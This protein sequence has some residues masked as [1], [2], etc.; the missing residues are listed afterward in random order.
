[1]EGRSGRVRKERTESKGLVLAKAS[2]ERAVDAV[3]P[4]EGMAGTP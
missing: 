2:N 1:M 4:R 3:V